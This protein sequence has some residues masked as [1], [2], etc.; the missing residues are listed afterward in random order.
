MGTV[1]NFY[2]YPLCRQMLLHNLHL[3]SQS[4]T[5]EST[6]NKYESYVCFL[7]TF[8][9][10]PHDQSSIMNICSFPW[11]SI[12]FCYF[13]KESHLKSLMESLEQKANY[14]SWITIVF[15]FERVYYISLGY[16]TMSLQILN[17]VTKNNKM[18]K[19]K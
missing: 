19:M 2:L 17:S 9:T 3:S 4:F 14:Y 10:L 1:S 15:V 6:H 11:I 18:M 8:F 7:I 16:H 13:E 12:D 5:N